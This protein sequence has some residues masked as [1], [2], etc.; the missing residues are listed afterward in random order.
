MW[1]NHIIYIII[2]ISSLQFNFS[3]FEVAGVVLE[4]IKN[5]TYWL[6]FSFRASFSK[7]DKK[8]DCFKFYLHNYKKTDFLYFFNLKNIKMLLRYAIFNFFSLPAFNQK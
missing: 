6:L 1:Y 2:Q 7:L 3:Q 4:P 5:E 8:F